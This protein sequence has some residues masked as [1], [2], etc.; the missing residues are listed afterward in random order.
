[1]Y[2]TIQAYYSR[3]D[4]HSCVWVFKPFWHKPE[5]ALVFDRIAF[6]DCS[7]GHI[8]ESERSLKDSHNGKRNCTFFA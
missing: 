6:V 1:M 5:G 7:I 8:L 3:W 4:H 2:Q